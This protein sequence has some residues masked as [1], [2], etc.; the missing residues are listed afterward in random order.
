MEAAGGI[1]VTE[2][3]VPLN[4][5]FAAD[6]NRGQDTFHSNCTMPMNN[7]LQCEREIRTKEWKFTSIFEFSKLG[8]VNTQIFHDKNIVTKKYYQ[9][10]ARNIFDRQMRLGSAE[11]I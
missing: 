3:K 1:H 10:L 9:V 2:K 5:E 6:F 4:K 11:L 8:M 7:V